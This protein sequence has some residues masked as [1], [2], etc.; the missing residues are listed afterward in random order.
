MVLAFP[1]MPPH[2]CLKIHRHLDS[3]M[4]KGTAVD[5]LMNVVYMLFDGLEPG[6]STVSV[7]TRRIL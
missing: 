6:T 7:V 1:S 4:I 5:E 3:L 2:S